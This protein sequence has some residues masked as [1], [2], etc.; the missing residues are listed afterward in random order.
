L[1]WLALEVFGLRPG[2]H[3][4]SMAVL[5]EFLSAL[6]MNRQLGDLLSEKD[7]FRMDLCIEATIPFRGMTAAGETHFEEMERR[8][9][10]IARRHNFDLTER[11][12][13]DT[14]R[15]AVM[16]GN[17]DIEN[18]AESDPGR[19]LDNTWKLLP[20][21]NVALRLPD[22]YSIGTYRLALQK[23][24]G[25]FRSL[26]PEVVFNQYR[27]IPNDEDYRQMVRYARANIKVARGYLKLKILSMTVLE[28]LA[29]ATGGD[30]PVS[31][32]MGD[33]PRE[34]VSIKRLEYFL[35]ELEDAPWVD[36]ASVIYKLLESGRASET[37]FDMK[38]SPLSLFVYKTIPPE[39]ITFYLEL[40]QKMFDNQLSAHNF[41][42][43]LDKLLVKSIAHASAMMVFT[44]RQ[45]LLKYA[46]LE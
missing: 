8:L 42:M 3:L 30:A 10:E 44:R 36:H 24:E 1:A 16:F 21:T 27:G 7:I 9:S 38:N 33:V 20:E 46:T 43:A 25:F 40:A 12:V 41:L 15:T 17:K 32:F 26:N 6:V 39:K 31:L 13:V 19:F 4:S 23:M 29:I 34:G 2:Q 22:V 28:A 37:S 11:E 14:L 18:F 5:N 45:A 35:P